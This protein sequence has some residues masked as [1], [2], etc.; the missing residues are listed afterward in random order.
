MRT[1]RQVEEN[2]LDEFLRITVEAFPGMKVSGPEERTRMLE[3]LARVMKEPIVHFFGVYEAARLIGV[4]RFYDF[5]MRLHATDALV[6]G[7]GGVAVD[8]R[9]KKERVAADMIRFFLDHYRA[10]GAALTALYPFR[11]DFYHRMGFGFG[12]KL[13]RYSFPPNVLPARPKARVEFLSA[14]DK[15]AVG[16]CYERFRARTNGLLR[17]PPHVLDSLFT[18][19]A[20]RL[21]GVRDGGRVR[22]YLLFR[23]DPAAGDNWLANDLYVRTMVYDDAATLAALLGFLRTQADQVQRVIYETQ[24]DT[25]HFLLPDPRDGTGNLLAGLW[26]ETNTQGAGIMYRVI[27][28]LRLFEVLRE[29]DFGGATATLGLTLTDS[30]LPE[31]AGRTVLRVKNGQATLLDGGAADVEIG[32]DVSNFSSLM[33]GAVDFARLYGYGLAT[34][35]DAAAVPLVDRLFRAGQRPWCMTHF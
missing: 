6:G 13:N 3:R 27:D 30:F 34:I 4:M 7:V 15:T 33:V 22:G 9:H 23:F 21:V 16:D 8:L 35:S 26:H 2:E 20:M 18:D 5:T 25:F 24:D 10:K 11:P 19:P 1:I 28:T 32:L 14:D 31:N 12:V 29:H 17:L